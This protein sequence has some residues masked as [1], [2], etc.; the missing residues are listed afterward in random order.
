MYAYTI[1]IHMYT[2]TTSALA[3]VSIS[4]VVHIFSR[5]RSEMKKKN[6]TSRQNVSPISTGSVAPISLNQ[7]LGMYCVLFI[8]NNTCS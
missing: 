2:H 4:I 3:S 6:A 1:Y 5:H 7:L 8:H